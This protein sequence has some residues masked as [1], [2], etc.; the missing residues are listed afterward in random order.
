MSDGCTTRPVTAS[1]AAKQASK[2]LVLLWSLRL[3]F[4]AIITNTLSTTVKGQ[5]MPLITVVMI[6]LTSCATVRGSCCTVISV[7]FVKLD[8]ESLAIFRKRSEGKLTSR[9]ARGF[10]FLVVLIDLPPR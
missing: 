10:L 7:T 3:L 6:I 2:M 9:I 8:P 4:T 5:V 1:V